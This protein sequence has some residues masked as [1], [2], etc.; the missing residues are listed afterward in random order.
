MRHVMEVVGERVRVGLRLVVVVHA[1]ELLP[2]LVIAPDLNQALRTS[3]TCSSSSSY[4]RLLYCTTVLYS[5]LSSTAHH[6]RILQV[7]MYEYMHSIL[8]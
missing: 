5:I 4:S 6:V 8:Y 1:R 3:S 2:A 7:D